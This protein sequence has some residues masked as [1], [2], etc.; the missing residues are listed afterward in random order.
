MTRVRS[1]GGTWID[2]KNARWSDSTRRTT[3]VSRPCRDPKWWIS[4]RWL[5]PAP[6]AIS[7]RERSPIPLTWKSATT[8]SRRSCLAIGR[9][10]PSGTVCTKWYAEAFTTGAQ[11]DANHHRRRARARCPRR[12]PLPLPGRLSDAPPPRG[13]SAAGLLGPRGPARRGR[14]RNRGDLDRRRRRAPDDHGRITEPEPGHT[15]LET[16]DGL[17]TT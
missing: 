3:S 11:T 5:V 1:S 17:V 13:L 12:R 16:A 6:A 4:I 2:V 14:R 9:S 10:V 7:R 8:R 15:L